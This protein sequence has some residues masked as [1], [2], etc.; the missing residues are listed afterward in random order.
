MT[1]AE[2]ETLVKRLSYAFRNRLGIGAKAPGLDVVTCISSNHLLLPAMFMGVVG[3]GGVYASASSA[4]TVSELTRQIQGSGSKT[5]IASDDLRDTASEA[6]RTC[7]IPPERVLIIHPMGAGARR[8]LTSLGDPS[9][10]YL[11]ETRE[12]SWERM[13]DKKTLEDRTAALLYSS[14]T[15]GPPKGVRL[16]HYNFVAEAMITQ[17]VLETYLSRTGR[18]VHVDYHYRAIAHLPATHIAGLQ[19]YFINNIMAGGTVYWLPKFV[20]EKFVAAVARHRPTF[21]PSVP[22]VYLRIAKDPDVTDQ[23]HSVENAQSGAAPMGIELQKMA[24]KKF[25]CRISQSWGLTETTGAVTWLPWD[26]VDDTGSISQLMPN[27]RMMIVDDD[28]KSVPD[29]HAGE[30][31]VKGPNLTSGY[32]NNPEA[33]QEAITEDGW[34]RTGDIGLRRDAKFYI[35]DR[36][37]VLLVPLPFQSDL[38]VANRLS[39]S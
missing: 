14:G 36:K 11:D 9:R 28:G 37:K 7:G 26:R 27:T 1:K 39:R 4:L 8:A 12:L 24:E 20:W 38:L 34:F 21:L 18:R 16:S 32:W 6:A 17:S 31:L 2:L 30:I 3:A 25:K 13:S 22:A 23:F 19:G 5:V 15:T 35:I 33:T 29:G 10:N